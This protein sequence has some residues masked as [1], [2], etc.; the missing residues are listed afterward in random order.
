M[1]NPPLFCHSPS[2]LVIASIAR[3]SRHI[4]LSYPYLSIIAVNRSPK[5][6]E[7]A[8]KQ[9]QFCNPDDAVVAAVWT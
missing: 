1:L 7:G 3:Q 6:S 5:W 2:P 4:P 8:A 9:F